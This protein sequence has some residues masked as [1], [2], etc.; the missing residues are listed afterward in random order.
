MTTLT[1]AAVALLL[2]LSACSAES[3]SGGSDTFTVW[4]NANDAQINSH[5]TEWAEERGVDL[6]LQTYS[7]PFETTVL[8][9]WNTG[10]RPD[11]LIFQTTSGWIPQ[12]NPA[13]TLID[14]SDQPA[15]TNSNIPELIPNIGTFDG[16]QYGVMASGLDVEGMF[17]NKELFETAGLV[18]PTNF[19]ELIQTCQAFRE[20]G[21]TPIHTAGADSWTLQLIPL[22]L[23][24]DAIKDGDLMDRLN[25]NEASFTDP[26]LVLALESF[27][28]TLDENCH[29]ENILTAAYGQQQAALMEGEA[30]M[31]FQGSWYLDGLTAAYDLAE[32]DAVIGFQPMSQNGPTVT[33]TSGMGYYVPMTG[34]ADS[35]EAA[36]D[37][38][39]WAR[40]DGYQSYL[41][42][43]GQFPTVEGF[44]N[45]V[46]P[47]AVRVQIDDA[48]RTD[49]AFVIESLQLSDFGPLETFLGEMA[50]G[51]ATPGDVAQSL[52]AEWERTGRLQELPG[53]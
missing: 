34:N 20:Q 50:A 36:I 1:S 51:S 6:D 42:A 47:A 2:T 3:D 48:I 24:T 7:E 13:E 5:I 45:P 41:D 32:I 26:E 46:D 43:T 18:P 12:L 8:T 52:Q 17:Y 30:A 19:A 38:V 15:I 11:L 22:V 49:S 33:V 29:N 9:K 16:R 35:E 44:E 28:T 25:R 31:V 4:A 39:N 40:S 10:E 37:F 21:I 53:F 23:W 14:L 27:Q